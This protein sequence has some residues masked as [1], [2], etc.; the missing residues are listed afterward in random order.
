MQYARMPEA[1]AALSHP[2][3]VTVSSASFVSQAS[4]SLKPAFVIL[5]SSSRSPTW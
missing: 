4:V 2:P 3:T 5:V 1:D